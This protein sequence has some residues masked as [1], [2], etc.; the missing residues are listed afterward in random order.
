MAS[1]ARFMREAATISIAL[2]IWAMFRTDPIRPRMSFRL[3]I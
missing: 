3:A 1:C 2:V